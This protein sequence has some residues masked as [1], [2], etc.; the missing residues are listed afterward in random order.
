MYKPEDR[1]RLNIDR[2]L[3]DAGW[4]VQ[5]RSDLNLL[6]GRGVAIREFS[7]KKGAADYLLFVDEEPVGTVEAKKE[8][9]T[10]IG[11]EEQSLKY[12]TGLAE[13]FPDARYPLPFSY[14]TTGRASRA[15][16]VFVTRT[17]D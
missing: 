7:V 13:D 16:S 15:L 2:M 1:A 14:E 5:D 10:L 12:R 11:V 9:E 4:V 8:G 17:L 3:G 6:A